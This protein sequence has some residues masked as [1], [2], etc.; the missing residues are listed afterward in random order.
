M[1][2]IWVESGATSKGSFEALYKGK[3]KRFNTFYAFRRVIGSLQLFVVYRAK[4]KMSIYQV[5]FLHGKWKL[6][7]TI[8]TNMNLHT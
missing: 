6:V 8:T 5:L 4:E 7:A 1:N 3:Y 2:A